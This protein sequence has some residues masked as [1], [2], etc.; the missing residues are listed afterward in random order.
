MG[1]RADEGRGT[2]D[3]H[4]VHVSVGSGRDSLMEQ[5]IAT[6]RKVVIDSNGSYEVVHAQGTFEP[7]ETL[8][9]VFQ[10]A[11]HHPPT[12]QPDGISLRPD[13]HGDAGRRRAEYGR[14]VRE[15]D[16]QGP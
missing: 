4:S 8:Q 12:G 10:W 16:T 13:E 2:R 7:G 11:Q 3:L 15:S 6:V 9:D 5:I 1:G 14:M